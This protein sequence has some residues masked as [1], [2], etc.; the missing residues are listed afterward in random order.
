MVVKDDNEE[1]LLPDPPALWL[2]VK[3]DFSRLLWVD[4]DLNSFPVR[5]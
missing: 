1:P 5:A 4:L 3:E 2:D